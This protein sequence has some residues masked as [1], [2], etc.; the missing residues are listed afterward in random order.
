MKRFAFFGWLTLLMTGSCSRTPID[1]GSRRDAE[2]PPP[3]YTGYPRVV[4]G[5][6]WSCALDQDG[7]ATCWGSLLSGKREPPA[8]RFVDLD[9]S[10]EGI[11]I[12]ADGALLC[13]TGKPKVNTPTH[14]PSGRFKKVS[15]RGSRACGLRLDDALVCWGNPTYGV[16][17]APP[18]RFRDVAVGAGFACAVKLDGQMVCWGGNGG[19]QASAPGGYFTSVSAASHAC[20]LIDGERLRCW[21]PDSYSTLQDR[22]VRAVSVG[23][24]ATCAIL[25]DGTVECAH[26]PTAVEIPTQAR[27]PAG[28]FV[29]I[30]LGGTH[31]CGVRPGGAIECWGNDS[32]GAASPPSR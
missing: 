15:M 11:G 20:G 21:G 29:Q 18:G 30:D 17:D 14:I 6:A 32:D 23:D 7:K 19:G 16:T 13:W 12:L 9:I 3:P 24:Y 22:R 8:E 2:P 4:A 5:A 27:P 28:Q 26:S 10:S 1:D 25:L 31:A